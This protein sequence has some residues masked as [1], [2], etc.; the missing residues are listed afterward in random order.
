MSTLRP[1]S[2]KLRDSHCLI[3][4]LSWVWLNS[5]KYHMFSGWWWW[6]FTSFSFHHLKLCLLVHA[7]HWGSCKT[8]KG[9]QFLLKVIGCSDQGPSLTPCILHAQPRLL[10][11]TLRGRRCKGK[12]SW[13]CHGC[14][15]ASQG[16]KSGMNPETDK[17][18][19]LQAPAEVLPDSNTYEGVQPHTSLFLSISSSPFDHVDIVV[20][21]H[22][23]YYSLWGKNREGRYPLQWLILISK[24]INCSQ[25][26]SGSYQMWTNL[27]I[28]YWRQR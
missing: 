5:W 18:P 3:Q 26:N 14:F 6:G 9:D 19:S 12:R 22:F 17:T 28:L 25:P 2:Y 8:K 21:G 4:A 23:P 1:Q 16:G 7:S 10:E 20:L 27:I 13:W 11:A 15:M 24:I